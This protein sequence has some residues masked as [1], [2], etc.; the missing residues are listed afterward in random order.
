ME[1]SNNDITPDIK[2][3]DL[4]PFQI[5]KEDCE[6][7]VRFLTTLGKDFKAKPSNAVIAAFLISSVGG[8][9]AVMWPAMAQ[10]TA[11][12]ID[13]W[14]KVGDSHKVDYSPIDNA[15][16]VPP[17]DTTGIIVV[18]QGYLGELRPLTLKDPAYQNYLKETDA[19]IKENQE[20]NNIVLIVMQEKDV[21]FDNLP[22][23][24]P[25]TF[26]LVT[27][28]GTGTFSPLFKSGN[29]VYQQDIDETFKTL[30]TTYGID[31]YNVYGEFQDLCVTAVASELQLKG[32][33]SLVSP[34]SWSSRRSE[35]EEYFPTVAPNVVMTKTP[36]VTISSYSY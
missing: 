23:S 16:V 6:P 15:E 14:K 2:G 33:D 22:H 25:N 35:N 17:T 13:F 18:H 31:K 34:S 8:L 36:S 30:H 4:N 32:Y 20:K 10:I 3:K 26:Y 7:Y 29:Q 24:H 19:L 11:N 12:E 9:Y 27:D 21:D 5:L 28:N 1:Q